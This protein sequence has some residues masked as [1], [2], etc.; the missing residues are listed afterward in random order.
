MTK[1]LKRKVTKEEPKV[2][3]LQA[4]TPKLPDDYR[5]AQYANHITVAGTEEEIIFDLFQGGSEAGG[6][7]EARVVFVSRLIFPIGIAKQIISRLQ[8]LVNK[9]EEDTGRI[10]PES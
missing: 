4:E 3:P 5:G 7:V 2:Y 10:I 8:G 6:R 9:I 1:D